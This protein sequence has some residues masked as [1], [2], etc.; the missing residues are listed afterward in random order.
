MK[1]ELT[2]I[3]YELLRVFK[4]LSHEEKNIILA[5]GRE[6]SSEQEASSSPCQKAV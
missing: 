1:I 3:E 6:L 2:P 4:S 5:S